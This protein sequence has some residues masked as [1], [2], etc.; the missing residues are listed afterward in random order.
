MDWGMDLAGLEDLEYKLKQLPVE[1]GVK[2]LTAGLRKAGK[3]VLAKAQ[4]TAPVETGAYK[5]ALRLRKRKTMKDGTVVFTVGLRRK[6]LQAK[7]FYGAVLEWGAPQE[8]IVGQHILEN[9]ADSTLDSA[10]GVVVDECNKALD[11]VAKKAGIKWI[12]Q[13]A[14]FDDVLDEIEE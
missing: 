11:R 6:D 3:L 2:G 13:G 8:G 1:V 4:Q 12:D 5:A 10:V 9:A 14:A 7:S